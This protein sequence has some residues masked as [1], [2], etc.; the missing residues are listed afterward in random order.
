[1]KCAKCG[2]RRY[3]EWCPYCDTETDPK[4]SRVHCDSCDGTG[5]LKG[6]RLTGGR[7]GTRRGTMLRECFDCM[8]RGFKTIRKINPVAEAQLRSF[9]N[10]WRY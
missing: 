1:M 8:G 3:R 4:Y 6:T 7:C 10:G 2:N 5:R 9:G